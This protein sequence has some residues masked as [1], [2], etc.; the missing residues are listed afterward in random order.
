MNKRIIGLDILRDIGVIF[1]FCYHFTVE[2]IITAGGTEGYM[3]GLN[4]FF[5]ILA[6]PASLFL[7]VISGYA[8]MYNH[9]DTLPVL[10]FYKRRIKG[11]FIPFYVAYTVMFIACF[12]VNNQSNLNGIPLWH[13]IFT[14]LGLDGVMQLKIPVFYLIGEWFMTCI[15]VCYALFPFLARLL[16]KWPYVT[17]GLLTAW[18]IVLLFFFNPFGF[19]Q[20]MNPLLIIVYFYMGM[21]LQQILTRHDIPRI[22]TVICSILSV[23]GFIFYYLCGFNATFVAIRPGNELS[24]VITIV[25]S[26]AMIIALMKVEIAP[27]KKIYKAITYVSGISWYVILLHHRI[28]ILFYSHYSVETY[29]RRDLFALFLTCLV[30]TWIASVFV[31]NIAKKIQTAMK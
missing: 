3:Y 4:Y 15:V 8:L 12:V 17:M 23:A 29:T 31:R 24:E 11:L 26:M 5:N 16:K 19:S 18:Y 30:I 27:E 21:L 25:W 2:Y 13:F 10:K 14:L 20:L 7:F 6:R 22:L 1:I 28:M 9:E